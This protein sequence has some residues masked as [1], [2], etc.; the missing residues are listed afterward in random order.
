MMGFI[1]NRS[2]GLKLL[3]LGLIVGL[4]GIPLALV[5]VLSWEREARADTAVREVSATYGGQQVVRGP[6]LVL[7]YTTTHQNWRY[8]AG[9]REM[10]ETTS[11]GRIVIS[12][13][14]L[15]ITAD[16]AVETRHRGIYEIPVYTTELDMSAHFSLSSG[17]ALLPDNS[18]FNWADAQ[19]VFGFTGFRSFNQ[20]LQLEIDGY[21][22]PLAIEPGSVFDA[23]SWRGVTANLDGLEPG[24]ELQTRARLSLTGASGFRFTPSGRETQVS[25][26]SDWPHPGFQGGFLPTAREITDAGYSAEWTIPYLARGVPAAWDLENRHPS[27][28]D[29]HAFGVDLVTPADGYQ[30]VG[31]SLKYALFF[32]GFVMLMFFLIEANSGRRIHPAQYILAGMAQVIFYLLLLAMSEHAGVPLAFILATAA[33]VGL[34]A[35]YAATVFQDRR[36]GLLTALAMAIVYVTQYVLILM[37]DYA[38]LI[39]S[40]MAFGGLAATMVLTRRIDWY[41]SDRGAE[42]A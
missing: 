4:L 36:I 8:V 32:I 11:E 24:E 12:A 35:Y 41:N 40:L 28:L 16:Q 23:A 25:I 21:D 29:L 31:R 2:L 5:S 33:T 42:P 26:R 13:E 30:Q 9:T 39:G 1:K 6:F 3:L 20:A 38:L 15:V 14:R 34:S 27:T 10:V 17:E 22:A 18:V 19:L 37:E 7:P